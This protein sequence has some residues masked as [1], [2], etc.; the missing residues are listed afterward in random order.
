MATDRC[1]CACH[2]YPGTY[3]PPCGVCGHDDREGRMVGGYR[4]GWEANRC[5]HGHARC[6]GHH[7]VEDMPIHGQGAC[8]NNG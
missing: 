3:P 2:Q 7:D 1:Y 5:P 8:A 4:D 6:C